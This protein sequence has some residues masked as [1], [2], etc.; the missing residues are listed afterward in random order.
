MIDVVAVLAKEFSLTESQVRS[1]LQLASEGG[2]VPFIARYRKERTGEMSEPQ[3]RALL[4]RHASLEELEGRKQTVLKAIEEEGRLTDELRSRIDSCARKTELEDIS[5]PFRPKKRTRAA[6]A[7]EKGLEAL[8]R[9]IASLNAPDVTEADLESEAAKYVSAEKGVATP[10]EALAGASDILSEEIASKGEHRSFLRDYIAREGVFA[11]TIKEKYPA[12]TTKFEMY[13]DYKVPVKSVQPHN[14][15]AMRRGERSG[16]IRV[17]IVVNEEFV[18]NHLEATELFAANERVRRFYSTMLKETYQ[19]LLHDPLVNEVRSAKK[20][21]ADLE[22]IKTFEANLRDVLLSAPVGMKPIMGVAPGFKSGCKVAAIDS[23]GKLIE[24]HTI[25]PFASPEERQKAAAVVT[26][27]LQKHD[28]Q[29]V[30]VG[31]GAGSRETDQFLTEVLGALPV[32]P[33]KITVN[34]AGASVY[35]TSKLAKEEFANMDATVRAAISIGR[36]LQDPLAELVKIDPRSIGVGQYQ[37]DVD[38]KLLKRKLEETVQS[39]VNYVSVDVNV[40]SRE[41]LR[42]VAGMNGALASNIVAYRTEHGSFASREQLRNVSGMGPNNFEQAAGFL[43]IRGGDNPLDATGV[44]PENYEVAKQILTDLSLPLEDLPKKP[45][46]LK[47]ADPHRYVTETL[48]EGTLRDILTE[49]QR[50]GK[51]PRKE[52]RYATFKEEVKEI[53][54]LTAGM[55]LEGVVTNVTNFGAFVDVGVHHDGLVH[56]SQLADRYVSDPKTIVKV[57][58]IVKVK[59]LEVNEPLKRISLTMKGMAPHPPRPKKGKKPPR[60][61]DEKTYTLDDLKSKFSN[62]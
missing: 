19:R 28:I 55:E 59:V 4:D 60:P 40:A 2:S 32:K 36:R 58:Q 17:D 38:Q 35:S 20:E 14:V 15:L 7:R 30:A 62:R 54:D 6:V 12:G 46:L 21:Y 34:E 47:K 5:L 44:H 22:S 18:Q 26:E 41:L 37:H 25:Y 13:R 31:N 16:I 45:F 48:G 51:D 50:S 61:R 3:L 57:G 53:K 24:H 39:C 11:S 29:F 33:L 52:F 9:F 23:T 56:V 49:L 27:L 10:E 1:A 8:A 42:Y 43:R